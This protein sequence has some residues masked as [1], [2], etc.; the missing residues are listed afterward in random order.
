MG[1]VNLTPD[2]FSD[3]GRL[4]TVEAAVRHALELVEDGAD[5]LDVGGESTRPG[6]SPVTAEEEARRVLPVLHE[7]RPRVGVPI[8]IDTT[9]ASVARAALDLGCDVVNDVS[10]L[11]FDPEMREVLA[12][13]CCGVVLMHMQGEPRTMQEAPSYTDVVR[14]VGDWLAARLADCERGGIDPARIVLDP[15][16]GFGK[17]FEDNLALLRGLD[18]LRRGGRPLLVGASRKAFLGKILGE[19]DP[20]RRIEGDLAIAAWCRRARVEILRVHDVRAARR[21]LRVF[22]ALEGEAPAS[23]A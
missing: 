20:A 11:R 8:S 22:D 6:A 7:L 10:G 21:L 9:K 3:G 16:I 12:G 4:A 5:L 17:R 19:P 2:S 13:A 18:R 23:T 15:G 1:V 14:E